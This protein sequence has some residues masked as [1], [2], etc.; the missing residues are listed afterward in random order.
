MNFTLSTYSHDTESILC[1]SACF[2]H[3]LDD[4]TT[5]T[6]HIFEGL[7]NLGALDRHPFA[8]GEGALDGLA[9]R[10]RTAVDS[11]RRRLA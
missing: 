4:E 9:V 3:Y 5:R 2:R 7:S 11:G 8:V 10:V 6:P 1:Q